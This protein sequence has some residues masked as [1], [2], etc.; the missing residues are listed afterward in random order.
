MYLGNVLNILQPPYEAGNTNNPINISHPQMGKLRLVDNKFNI[1]WVTQPR[2]SK[3]EI[4]TYVCLTPEITV[5][6]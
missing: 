1:L 6:N 3:V 4:Q 5:L 2:S